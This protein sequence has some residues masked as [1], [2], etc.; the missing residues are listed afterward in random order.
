MLVLATQTRWHINQRPTQLEPHSAREYLSA[1]AYPYLRK[2][3]NSCLQAPRCCVS[4]DFRRA[5]KIARSA[6]ALST[7]VVVVKS[8]DGPRQMPKYLSISQRVGPKFSQPG[9]S[10]LFAARSSQLARVSRD[11]VGLTTY[12]IRFNRFIL[13]HFISFSSS[14][15]AAEPRAKNQE[16]RIKNARRSGATV[17]A[18]VH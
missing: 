15:H 18:T 7:V 10:I 6:K 12:Y 14:Q 1:S 17:T 8:T 3:T 11:P 9:Q 2:R 4:W 16:P 13:G 5:A